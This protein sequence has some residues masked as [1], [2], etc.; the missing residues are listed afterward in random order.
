MTL[1]QL[2]HASFIG[3]H[4]V[5]I[6]VQDCVLSNSGGGRRSNG[7]ARLGQIT[8]FGVPA[9]RG[10]SCE[11]AQCVPQRCYSTSQICRGPSLES[12][13]RNAKLDFSFGREE[14]FREKRACFR[15]A[16]FFLGPAPRDI[17]SVLSFSLQSCSS[18]GRS[19]VSHR[20]VQGLA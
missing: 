18:Y 13:H 8:E 12:A 2:L 20:L 14:V 15:L 5:I 19:A 1:P 6:P 3:D 4:S 17:G 16:Q 11:K 9:A 7:P 10:C